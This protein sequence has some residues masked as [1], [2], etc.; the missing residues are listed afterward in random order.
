VITIKERSRET[1]RQHSQRVKRRKTKAQKGGRARAKVLRDR[2]ARVEFALEVCELQAKKPNLF[3]VRRQVSQPG[4]LLV[5]EAQEEAKPTYT[6]LKLLRWCAILALQVVYLLTSKDRYLWLLHYLKGSGETM[7]VSEKNMREILPSL[8]W[9]WSQGC[10]LIKSKSLKCGTDL[11]RIGF[12]S[13]TLY[14]GSGF[15]GRPECF[16]ILGC[17]TFTL[18]HFRDA[19]AGEVLTEVC[20]ADHYD[21]HSTGDGQYYTSPMPEWII[22]ILGGFFGRE[23]FPLRGFPMGEPGISN[24]LWEDL[25]LVGAKPFKTRFS[26]TISQSEWL[27]LGD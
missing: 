4:L 21:W 23:Y 1:R 7:Y 6:K 10:T 8:H 2:A 22:W 27:G 9:V 14:R 17:F 11:S 20:G 24:K 5:T 13:T 25:L 12:W 26:V 18:K 3:A 16:Y 15:G 19:V